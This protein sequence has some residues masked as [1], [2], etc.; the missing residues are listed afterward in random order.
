MNNSTYS[1]MLTAYYVDVGK[2]SIIGPH[3]TGSLL[4]PFSSA[5]RGQSLCSVLGV[6]ESTAAADAIAK[7]ERSESIIKTD[8]SKNTYCE[9]CI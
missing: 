7:M 1:D 8:Q 3:P 4:I 2:G 6:L 9:G 5:R